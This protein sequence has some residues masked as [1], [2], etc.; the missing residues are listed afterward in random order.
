MG[1]YVHLAD[2]CL[3]SLEVSNRTT[4]TDSKYVLRA[5]SASF[6]LC[7]RIVTVGLIGSYSSYAKQRLVD[8]HPNVMVQRSPSHFQ[9][10]TFYWAHVRL[11]PSS[12]H[13]HAYHTADPTCFYE[14]YASLQH[15]KLCVIDQTIAFMGGL[16]LCFGR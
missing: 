8:L 4:P 1:T 11:R 10:G 13:N 12:K 5:V 16:D 3:C 15:E 6:F 14:S 9:T 7:H 2:R